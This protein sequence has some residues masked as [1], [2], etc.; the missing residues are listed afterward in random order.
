MEQPRK[1]VIVTLL[2]G[3]EFEADVPTERDF[4]SQARRMLEDGVART[5]EDGS[6]TFYPAR[7]IAK[8]TVTA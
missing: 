4:A 5:H 2:D 3:F 7:R 6:V 1:D 8:V